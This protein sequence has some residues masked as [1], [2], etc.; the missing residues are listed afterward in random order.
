MT[1]AIVVAIATPQGEM[2]RVAR[3]NTTALLNVNAK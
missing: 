3:E 1:L 2:N